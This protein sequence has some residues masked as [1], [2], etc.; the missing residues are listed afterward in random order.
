M[1]EYEALLVPSKG[2]VSESKLLKYMCIFQFLLVSLY[3][4]YSCVVFKDVKYSGDRI[5]YHVY[6]C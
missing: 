3:N 4:L 2:G 1:L 6:I 5:P